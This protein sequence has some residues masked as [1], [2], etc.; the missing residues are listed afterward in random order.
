MSSKKVGPSR[1]QERQSGVMI[2]VTN[3]L[4]AS[5]LHKGEG[6]AIRQSNP[7]SPEL[8]E[9]HTAIANK[10]LKEVNAILRKGIA[11]VNALHSDFDLGFPLGHAFEVGDTRI[12]R[13][14]LKAG[15]DP[16]RVEC[17]STCI[18]EN[19]VV[20]AKLL[21]SHG[22][23]LNGQ[24]TWEKDEEF[25]TSLIQAVRASRYAIA[26]A[27]LEAGADPQRHDANDE[28]AL[29]VA[30]MAKNK[31]LAKL[32]E[33]YASEKERAWVE[34]RFSEAY[35]ERLQIDQE[36][37]Y[38]IHAEEVKCVL[39]LFETTGR[40]L[41]TPLAPEHGFPLEEAIAS[42][43]NAE[44][45]TC[46][47]PTLEQKRAGQRY[48]T[49]DYGDPSV[50]KIRNLMVWLLDN[51]APVDKGGW[52]TPLS[53]L[54]PREDDGPDM[55][56]VRHMVDKLDD[57]DSPL[58]SSGDTLLML[59]VRRRNRMLTEIA[60]KRGANVNARDYHGESVFQHSR[61]SEQF[62]GPNPC[63]PLLLEA[64]ARE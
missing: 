37:F 12:I 42:Y 47:E 1:K 9:L 29:F 18:E 44:K 36:I 34:E 56:L 2:N 55:D 13:A 40:P 48:G 26:K 25:E 31:R 43:F 28:S 60:I 19:N 21:I 33:L 53:I 4:S 10:S 46:A 17:M 20:V 7:D 32:I 49:P 22:V 61:S 52:R 35:S 3:D 41:D 54:L 27:L 24:P 50:V 59:A 63:I 16:N 39:E 8:T 64:G 38:A 11:D 58:M 14:L 23:D 15:A 30:R 6:L 5:A 62:D 57:I 45:A 51:G